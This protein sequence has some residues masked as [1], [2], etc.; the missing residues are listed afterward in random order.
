MDSSVFFLLVV[1]LFIAAPIPS[2]GLEC[3]PAQ[4]YDCLRVYS[5]Y[6][7]SAA[8]FDIPL[9]KQC[10]LFAQA[11]ECLDS[12][13]RTCSGST[14]D[15]YDQKRDGFKRMLIT[16]CHEPSEDAEVYNNNTKCFNQY[17]PEFVKCYQQFNNT[18]RY[19]DESAFS[20]WPCCRTLARM[21]CNTQ[22]LMKTCPDSAALLQ[23]FNDYANY[24]AVPIC[25]TQNLFQ[26]CTSDKTL[27]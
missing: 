2:N 20:V 27:E 4:I 11:E 12:L 6:N 25:K 13:R 17:L 14:I 1:T 3:T 22:V 7:S 18:N 9:D 5:T 10:S 26:Y 8:N 24:Q 19:D 15:E 16:L 23:K 21:T